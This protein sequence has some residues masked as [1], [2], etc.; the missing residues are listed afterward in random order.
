V[1][2]EVSAPMVRQASRSGRTS[3]HGRTRCQNNGMS[4]RRSAIIGIN[5]HP[6]T[7]DHT[8]A[9][10]AREILDRRPRAKS[11]LQP[12]VEPHPSQT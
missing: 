2:G 10:E 8:F 9:P 4:P 1:A 7:A 5:G 3:P 6:L 12:L 11:Q